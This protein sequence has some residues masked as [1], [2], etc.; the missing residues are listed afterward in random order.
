MHV[1]AERLVNAMK[2]LEAAFL[3][4]VE[5]T[6]EI[7]FVRHGDCY[8]GMVDDPDPALSP[9]GRRQAE[10]LAARVRRL[11]P[12]AVYTSPARRAVETA[13]Q[14][15]PDPRMD[16]RLVEMNFELTE[17]NQI[18]F[19]ETPADVVARVSAVVEEITAA[20]PG[21]RVIVVCHGGVI[22]SYITEV[23][24][25][26]PAGLRLLPYYTSVS[27]VRALDGRRI[28]ATVGDTSHLE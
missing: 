16:E 28:V 24:G 10:L 15:H 6:T 23:L 21:G 19:T 7:W 13:R 5:G 1:G 17:D 22:I 27:I 12:A 3:I 8:E 9:T 26:A 20:H 2:S 14:I 4:G 25:A 18:V 11:K